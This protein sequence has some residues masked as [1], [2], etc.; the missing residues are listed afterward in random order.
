MICQVEEDSSC[1][2]FILVWY[3]SYH[4]AAFNKG[5]CS[6]DALRERGYRQVTLIPV[7]K[8]PCIKLL[9]GEVDVILLATKRMY[10]KDVTRNLYG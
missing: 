2:V 7:D 6:G 4:R 3:T 10:P 1:N 8:H 5:V 9:H